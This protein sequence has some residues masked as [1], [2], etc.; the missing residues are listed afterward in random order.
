LVLYGPKVAIAVI[1][2]TMIFWLW[3]ASGY[4][5]INTHPLTCLV[6]MI[7]LIV[8]FSLLFTLVGILMRHQK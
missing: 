7:M 4:V 1:I 3:W 5:G 6:I 2:V 8:N